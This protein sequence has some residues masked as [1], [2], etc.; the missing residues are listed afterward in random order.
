MQPCLVPLFPELGCV[1]GSA[2]R[3]DEA[4][5]SGDSGVD[6]ENSSSDGLR[7]V[8]PPIYP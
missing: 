1:F 6:L 4:L 3:V 5:E 8:R 2:E 7:G